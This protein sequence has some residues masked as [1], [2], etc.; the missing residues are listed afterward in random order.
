MSVSVSRF[1]VVVV[2]LVCLFC[3]FIYVGRYVCRGPKCVGRIKWP[4]CMLKVILGWL[5]LTCDTRVIHFDYVLEQ[6]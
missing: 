2:L 6:L 1:V 3:L 4:T 5:K